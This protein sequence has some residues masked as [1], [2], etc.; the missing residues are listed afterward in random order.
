VEVQQ[1]MPR[2]LAEIRICREEMTAGQQHQ[3]EGIRKNQAQTDANLRKFGAG[4]ELNKEELTA[5]METN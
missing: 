5:K 4:Q 3:K 2:L 1:I